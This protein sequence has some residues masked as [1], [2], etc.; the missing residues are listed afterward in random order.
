MAGPIAKA[1]E[2]MQP[3]AQRKDI[4]LLINV[5]APL[6]LVN[7]DEG[8]LIESFVNLIGNAVKYSRPGSQVAVTATEQGED[9]VVSIADTGAGIAKDDLP[10]V[11][12]DFYR[13]KAGSQSAEGGLGLGLAITRRIVEAHDGT[14]SAASDPGKGSTFEIRLPI[15]KPNTQ[16]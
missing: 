8:S 14:I 5:A 10:F 9:M 3:H 11:F 4:T 6:P 12:E 16:K 1:V 13:G 7:G 2:S 15:V